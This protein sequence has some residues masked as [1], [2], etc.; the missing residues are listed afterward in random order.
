M[1]KKL[2]VFLSGPISGHLDTYQKEFGRAAQT[3]TTAGHIALNPAT[4]PLGLDERDYMRISVAM[5]EAA[6][7]VL[8][9]PGWGKSPGSIV[10]RGF[11]ARIGL[12]TMTMEEFMRQRAVRPIAPKVPQNDGMPI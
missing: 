10:E 9:L 1:E 11:A 8:L 3:V 4:M 5:M 12:P 2:K 7:L 6:D